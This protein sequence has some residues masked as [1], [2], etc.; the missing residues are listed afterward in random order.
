MPIYE[1]LCNSCG[2]KK[3]H[4]QKMSDAPIKVCPDC[5]SENYTKL[6]S[7]AG[8]QLKGSGWYVTDF[9]NK[10]APATAKSEKSDVQKQSSESSTDSKADS[11]AD[12]ATATPAAKPNETKTSTTTAAAD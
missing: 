4:I 3:E 8:F 9:K 5:H 6:V 1:Y 10:P 2:V 7:A 12:T 11:K